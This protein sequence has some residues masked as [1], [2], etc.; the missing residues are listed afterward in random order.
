MVLAGYLGFNF[1]LSMSG[2]TTHIES[3]ISVIFIALFA[4]P[5]TVTLAAQAFHS[6]K[7]WMVE[8]ELVAKIRQADLLCERAIEQAEGR[9][10]N[11][12]PTLK[13]RLSE[14]NTRVDQVKAALKTLGINPDPA[15]TEPSAP[16]DV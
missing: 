9:Y 6:M 3:P 12:E 10:L 11:Q 7:R 8:S 1:L 5:V 4:L 15:V 2:K 14:A 16:E 13:S